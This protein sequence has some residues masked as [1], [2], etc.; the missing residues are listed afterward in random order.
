MSK[1][2]FIFAP[3]MKILTRISFILAAIMVL[4]MAGGTVYEKFHGSEQAIT[5][6]YHAPWMVALWAL[7]LCVVTA[8][9]VMHRQQIRLWGWTMIAS[10]WLIFAGAVFTNTT[11]TSGAM[12]LV[13]GQATRTFT[14]DDKAMKELPFDVTLEDF[15]VVTYPGSKMPMDFVARVRFGGDSQAT[16]VSM[17]NIGKCQG[18]RFYMNDYDMKSGSIELLVSRD[19]LGITVTYLGFFLN[20]LAFILILIDKQ[21]RFRQL[22]SKTAVKAAMLFVLIAGG[23]LIGNAASRVPPTLPKSTAEKMGDIYIMYHDRICPM[24]TLAYDFTA[25]LYGKTS[26]KGLSAEQVLA[27]WIFYSAQWRDEPIIKIKGEAVKKVLGIRGKYASLNDFLDPNGGNKVGILLDSMKMD[28]PRRAE[29][30]A[31]N[32]KYLQIVSLY[33]GTLLKIYPLADSTGKLDWYSHSDDLPWQSLSTDTYN[34]VR[35]LVSYSQ[36]LVLQND[37]KN[38]N[39]VFEKHK[40]FQKKQAG[41]ILPS[42]GK[43]RA[44]KF[45]NRAVPGRWLA[46]L[47]LTLGVLLFALAVFVPRLRDNR[48]GIALRRCNF[49]AL[50]VLAIYLLM[51]FILRW[52]VKGYVPMAGGYETMMF[53][54]LCAALF[55]LIFS[56]RFPIVLSNSLLAIGFILLAAMIEGAQ[57]PVSHLM[58]VLKSPLLLIHVAVIMFAYALLAFTLLNSIAALLT[59]CFRKEWREPVLRLQH[60]SEIMLYPALFCLVAGIIIGS[61]WANISWGN[62]WSWDPKEVWALVTAIIYALPLLFSQNE[63]RPLLFHLYILLAFLSVLITYFGVNLILGGLHSY[64]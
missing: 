19:R 56:R 9:L 38:L 36:M 58:P 22:I 41:S 30:K 14:T 12:K 57:S 40:I 32:A 64:A 46:M 42:D 31:A 8:T 28:D 13:N 55:S 15:D 6:I 47:L 49:I 34:Y 18:Y 62:Y 52:I 23:T 26:Y 4:L 10:L 33:D 45:Y 35:K 63:K 7:L 1:S 16:T 3:Q 17:N 59:R 37:F 24:Q 11:G 50:C 48:F 2:F 43:F 29:F 39:V 20:L 44:E 21:S 60:T 27:G 54:A 25:Q 61:V 5:A 51:L 53:L